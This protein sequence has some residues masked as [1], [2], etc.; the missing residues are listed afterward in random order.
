VGRRGIAAVLL[1][2]AS[3]C[4]GESGGG[5]GDEVAALVTRAVDASDDA[6]S[7]RLAI[8][9]SSNVEG[10]EFDM[11]MRGISAPDQTRGRFRGTMSLEGGSPKSM[12]FIAADGAQFVRGAIIGGPVPEGKKWIRVEEAPT[13]T[14]TPSQFVEFLSQADGIEKVGTEQIRGDPAVHLRGPLDMQKLGEATSPE[15]ERFLAG[16]PD[17]VDVDIDAWIRKTDGRL[18]RLAMVMTVPNA[19]GSLRFG[20][21]LLDYD[22]PLDRADAPEPSTVYEP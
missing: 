6:E 4:G 21:D 1:L 18:T 12:E 7:Y 3:G 22:V 15:A 10:S 19:P 5:A 2:L 8:T 16:M 17:G 20:A 13:Q 9:G 14:L 11:R